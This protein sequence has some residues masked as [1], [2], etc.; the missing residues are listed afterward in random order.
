VARALAGVLAV[1]SVVPFWFGLWTAV[2]NISAAVQQPDPSLADGDPCCWHADD[3]TEVV[4]GIAFGLATLV[5]VVALLYVDLLLAR[6]ATTSR[7]P[8]R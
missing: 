1:A 7:P 3:W 2:I 5:A 4:A 6:F 8:G